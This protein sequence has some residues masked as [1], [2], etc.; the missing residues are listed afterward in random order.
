M[1]T[2]VRTRVV[3]AVVALLIVAWL[4]ILLRDILLI[5]RVNE[6]AG[7]PHP[8]PGQIRE[9]ISAARDSAL[10]NPNQHLP[11]LSQAVLYEAAHDTAGMIRI[12]REMVNAE[13]KDADIWYLLA[14]TARQADPR[15]SAAALARIHKLD[16]RF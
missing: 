4:T 13:P 10:L 6:I 3:L 11:L 12:Y 2:S 14:T 8:T 5:R 16:P 7:K 9:G 15:L 1:R